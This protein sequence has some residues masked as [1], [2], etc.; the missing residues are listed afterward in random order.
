MRSDKSAAHGGLKT[1]QDLNDRYTDG[2]RDILYD[3]DGDVCLTE[4]HN[5]TC[6][7]LIL[8]GSLDVICHDYHAHYIAK[9]IPNSR[10][11]VIPKGKHN[12]HMKYA[13][14]FRSIVSDFLS[15]RTDNL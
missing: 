1:L 2:M 6:P 4:L 11:E 8:H 15:E 7:T 13:D 9:C 5:I 3:Y 10:L 14:K 12:L